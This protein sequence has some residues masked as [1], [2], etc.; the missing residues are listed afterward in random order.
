MTFETAFHYSIE[1][2]EDPTEGRATTIK[3]QGK[4]T[5]ESTGQ[6]KELVKPIIASGGRIRYEIPCP[7]RF[8]LRRP[9]RSL[10]VLFGR[11]AHLATESLPEGAR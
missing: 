6:L 10:P 8:R 11:Q 9:T 1:K 2:S 3:F 5:S 7:F 4:L